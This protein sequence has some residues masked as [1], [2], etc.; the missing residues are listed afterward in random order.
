MYQRWHAAMFWVACQCPPTSETILKITPHS[1]TIFGGCGGLQALQK[2]Q[3]SR[4]LL[5]NVQ[6]P[7][8]STPQ[9]SHT[10]HWTSWETGAGFWRPQRPRKSILWSSFKNQGIMQ[11]RA[12][13]G[14]EQG[15]VNRKRTVPEGR[16]CMADPGE[17]WAGGQSQHFPRLT[18]LGEQCK[19]AFLSGNRAEVKAS[20]AA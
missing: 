16:P 12:V 18:G 14:R 2:S 6:R 11:A 19:V 13:S 8:K 4:A 15:P 20:W 10:L 7:H 5:H 9:F 1:F 17:C 3:E